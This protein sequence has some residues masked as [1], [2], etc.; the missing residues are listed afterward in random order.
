M[1]KVL[2]KSGLFSV[3][4]YFEGEIPNVGD[5]LE[6]ETYGHVKVIR[7]IFNFENYC[8]KNNKIVREVSVILE[9]N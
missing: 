4:Y 9:V 5:F 6:L 3:Q 7:R 8:S 2:I 1:N